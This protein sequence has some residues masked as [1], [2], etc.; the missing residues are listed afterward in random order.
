M[1][2]VVNISLLGKCLVKLVA[3]LLAGITV[4][5]NAWEGEE[6]ALGCA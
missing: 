3:N 5:G 2:T 1:L 4:T 6:C